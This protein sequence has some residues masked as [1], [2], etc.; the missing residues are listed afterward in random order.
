LS[1]R[2]FFPAQPGLQRSRSLHK[3]VA[4]EGFEPSK[5]EPGDLQSLVQLR[6]VDEDLKSTYWPDPTTNELVTVSLKSESHEL[7][8]SLARGEFR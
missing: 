1:L 7:I 6:E 2:Y 3:L 4:G 8:P 5:A